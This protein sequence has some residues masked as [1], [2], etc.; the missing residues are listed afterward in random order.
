MESDS[1]LLYQVVDKEGKRALPANELRRL[2]TTIG[3]Q[4]SQ[5]Q[6][7]QLFTACDPEGSGQIK[8]EKL[9]HIL[10]NQYNKKLKK[11]NNLVRDETIS[12]LYLFE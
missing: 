4:L 3:E 11:G 5:E 2:L 10:L 1:T 6:V 8:Y 9:A 7:N 12:F